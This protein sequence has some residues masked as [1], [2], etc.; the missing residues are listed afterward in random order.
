MK[1]HR[2]VRFNLL[3]ATV[4]PALNATVLLFALFTL[5]NRFV[6]QPGVALELPRSPFL[7]RP[8]HPP[9]ILSLVAGT[10][11]GL[12]VGDRKIEP[13]QLVATLRDY[14]AAERTAILRADRSIPHEQV[15]AIANDALRAG[16][17]VILAADT[18]E[19]P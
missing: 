15:M 10:A 14:P 3:W 12:W 13:A 1:L 5:G 9:L 19:A 7:L 17:E 16:F 8:E 4:V 2:N 6:L 11:P 18:A